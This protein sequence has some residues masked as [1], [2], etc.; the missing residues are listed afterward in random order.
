MILGLRYNGRNGEVA[1]GSMFYY[2]KYKK[3]IIRK[4]FYFYN[5]L[6]KNRYKKQNLE[7]FLEYCSMNIDY[8]KGKGKDINKYEYI[9]KS[10][11]KDNFHSFCKNEDTLIKNTVYT[12]GT[13]G[14]SCKFYY[15]FDCMTSEEY[16]IEKYFGWNNKY[17]VVFRGEKIFKNS[18]KAK[19][20]YR[21]VPF[22]KEM[23]VSPYNIDEYKL[24]GLVEKL[25]K[26]RNAFLYA[27]PSTAYLLAE[28]CLKNNEKIHFDVV[29]TS[30]EVLFD[31]QVEAIKNAFGC[32]L[33]DWYGQAER[34]AAL[35]KCEYGNY[36]EPEGSYS[37]IEYIQ[38]SDNTYEIAGTHLHNR[39]MP[40]IRYKTGDLV[41][42][43][44]QMCPC[45]NK[46]VNVTKIHGRIGDLI[47][48]QDRKITATGLYCA[49]FKAAKHIREAQIYKN[50]GSIIIRIVKEEGFCDSDEKAI[51][52]KIGDLIPEEM[53][54][55]EY[56]DEIKREKSGKFKYVV[57]KDSCVL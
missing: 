4:I 32:K 23:Y 14:T 29:A 53:Y 37:H 19:K 51:R 44:N 3:Y 8:Y 17:R 12:A 45:G 6:I 2:N 33:K 22:I 56:V 13:T 16:F 24:K 11:V 49:L 18:S 38:V 15:S 43:S 55:I 31:Y 30:S 54:S 1:L 36:H 28:Y 39:L 47:Q 57:N 52:D 5:K 25:K 34:V 27:Y 21:V 10:I 20:M 41:E 48:I 35:C 42:I 9:N 50:N 46:G 40:L 26:I 7:S